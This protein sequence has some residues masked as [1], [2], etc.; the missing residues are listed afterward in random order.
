[1]LAS[2]PAFTNRIALDQDKVYWAV[3]AAPCS[4][5]SVPKA[6]GTPTTLGGG[7]WCNAVATDADSV[8]WIAATTVRRAPKAGGTVVDLASFQSSPLGIAV[9][10]ENV[11]WPTREN[12]GP[13]TLEKVAKTSDGTAPVDDLALRLANP[14]DLTLVGT[15]LLFTNDVEGGAVQS[16]DVAGGPVTD[17]AIDTGTPLRIA[18]DA[19]HVYWTS[20]DRGGSG[21]VMRAAR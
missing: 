13:G 4:V 2:S 3:S 17:E 16:I 15:R 8:Y 5:L 6:G 10:G 9:D 7:D 11:Y 19:T 14:Y 1:V 12:M 21:R 18:A 20:Q